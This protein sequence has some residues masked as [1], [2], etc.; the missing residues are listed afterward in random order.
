MLMAIVIKFSQQK[1][2]IHT[3][4]EWKISGWP[5]F[6]IC[7]ALFCQAHKQFGRQFARIC[8][9]TYEIIKRFYN[10][11]NLPNTDFVHFLGNI[12]QRFLA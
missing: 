11:V 9:I 5:I 6:A 1:L 8:G 12:H 4:L 3:C 10:Q 2:V 7:P